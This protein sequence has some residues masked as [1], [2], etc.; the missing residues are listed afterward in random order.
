MGSPSDGP[1]IRR[2]QAMGQDH[3]WTQYLAKPEPQVKTAH[4]HIISLDTRLN[5]IITTDPADF[6]PGPP[7]PISVSSD[8]GI[9]TSLDCEEWLEGGH[10]P[11]KKRIRLELGRLERNICQK[12]LCGFFSK[13]GSNNASFENSCY[14]NAICDYYLTEETSKN[15]RGCWEADPNQLPLQP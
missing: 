8:P 5:N 14:L 15:P 1:Q 12:L 7:S 10:V 4:S 3:T 13:E 2:S 11:S 9:L 6:G